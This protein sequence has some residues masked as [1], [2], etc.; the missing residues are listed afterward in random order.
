LRRLRENVVKS[1]HVVGLGSSLVL[2]PS[3][4]SELIGYVDNSGRLFKGCHFAHGAGCVRFFR[5][6]CTSLTRADKVDLPARIH[7]S[8]GVSAHLGTVAERHAEKNA[9]LSLDLREQGAAMLQVAQIHVPFTVYS[10]LC[11][12]RL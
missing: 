2:N 4:E 1:G 8:K 11:L 10:P 7:G 6:Q 5:L 12:R 9:S 3:G